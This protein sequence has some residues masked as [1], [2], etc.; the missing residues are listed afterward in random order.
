MIPDFLKAKLQAEYG[1]EETRK[2]EAGYQQKR[3]SSIRINT[4]KSTKE[5]I[6]MQLDKE[7]IKYQEVSWSENALVILDEAEEKIKNLKMYH[8]GEIYFQ[9]LSSQLPPLFLNPKPK[10]L[11]LDMAAAPGGKTT[12]IAALTNN[13]AM[14][15]AIEKNKIRV[16][17]LK[18]NIEKQGAKRI[19]IL[20]TDAR[21]LDSY[22]F[23]DK[24][25]LD[26]PCSGSGTLSAET[27][28]SFEEDLIN[29]SIKV[30]RT[31]LEEAIK[32]LNS[33]GELIYSTCSILKEENENQI[34]EI[35]KQHEN[36]E[37]VSIDES[38]YEE[39]PKLPVTLPGTLCI[40]PTQNYEG[41]FIAKLKKVK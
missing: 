28:S 10:E 41:F 22:F 20:N 1:E 31:L 16:E 15:T 21:H 29:R 18:Y 11:I 23:F 36:I 40:L 37:L 27:I 25:L 26:A 33:N 6:R 34:K 24:I 30:Q 12:E 17:K 3:L 4:L 2:I 8:N 5:A 13:Q 14:I 9:S 32:H 7:K 39:I 38:A 35:L 19:T